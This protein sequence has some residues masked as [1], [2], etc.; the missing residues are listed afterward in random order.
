MCCERIFTVYLSL[1]TSFSE[2]MEYLKVGRDKD[3]ILYYCKSGKYNYIK[4]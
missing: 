2:T 3:K 4:D 1:E